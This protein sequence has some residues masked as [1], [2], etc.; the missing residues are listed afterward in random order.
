MRLS[1]MHSLLTR[2]RH[3]LRFRGIGCAVTTGGSRGCEGGGGRGGGG[4]GGAS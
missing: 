4:R 3:L 2:I 1:L